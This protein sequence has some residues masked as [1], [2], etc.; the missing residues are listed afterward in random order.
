MQNEML[1]FD[2][3]YS[4]LKKT[5]YKY[6]FFENVNVVSLQFSLRANRN[7]AKSRTEL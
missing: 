3:I 4:I 2:E 6:R 5:G 7:S 1:C